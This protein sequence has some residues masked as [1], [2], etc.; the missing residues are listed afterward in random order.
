MPSMA[1]QGGKRANNRQSKIGPEP[2]ER[3]GPR[4]QPRT[5]GAAARSKH[6]GYGLLL[7]ALSTSWQ[8]IW[9]IEL[10]DI[11]PDELPDLSAL[12]LRSKAVWGYDDAFMAACRTELTLGPDELNS[13]HIQVA[14]L[15]TFVTGMAQLKVTGTDA[16]LLKLFVE[17]ALLRSGVGAL[18]FEW[19]VAKARSLGAVRMVIEA[20]PGAASFYE[21]MGALHVGV[22]AS[23]SIPGR[24]LPR[25]LMEL[26][27]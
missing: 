18:L 5:S 6:A 22:A 10:R 19:A 4:R 13:T 1:G 8:D 2:A 9:M 3:A 11:R 17:P 27:S 14:E 16:E 15:G 7:D 25:L 20:D 12:C 26:T 24:V 23:Q 21:R